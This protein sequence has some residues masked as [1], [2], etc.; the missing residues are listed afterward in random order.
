V[1]DSECWLAIDQGGHASRAL[2]FDRRGALVAGVTVPVSTRRPDAARV[3]HDAEEIVASV[4]AAVDGVRAELGARARDVVA[5]GLAT[6][7]SSI[8]CWDRTDG[9]ALSPI[10]SWQDRRAAALVERL[11]GAAELVRRRSGL[12][13]SPH[14]GASKLRWCLDHLDAVRGAAARGRLAWGPLSSFLLFRLLRQRPHVVDPASASRT[15]LFDPE[16]GSW[17]RDLLELFGLSPEAL[18]ACVQSAH[19]FGALRWGGGELPLSVCTGDQSAALFAQGWPEAGTVAINMG[20]G[21][22]LQRPASTAPAPQSGLLYSV[23]WSDASGPLR[24]LE[25]TVNGAGAALEVAAGELWPAAPGRD[26]L[27][28]LEQWLSAPGPVPIFL[29]GVGGLGSPWWVSAFPSRFVGAGAP[30]RRMVAVVESVVFLLAAN[31]E[32]FGRAG[33]VCTRLRVSGGL[34]GSA[35]VCQRLA[36]V[37]GLPV[38]RP[39]GR[40]ATGR[41]VWF[42]L[43]RGPAHPEPV[44]R[45]LPAPRPDLLD[46]AASWREAMDRALAGAA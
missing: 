39:R 43:A 11:R 44:D 42:L 19:P 21:A 9:R 6:Q 7:R 5:A 26:R 46:R 10:L 18:P 28:R 33:G 17:D 37:S 13:L 23:A 8:A 30:S 41:G 27:G 22:F 31:L 16:A 45:F 29:N 36:D 15:L 4:R 25:G 14:Y 2:V 35:G 38:D 24:V 3:E 20:T 34:A 12:V 40:E 32:A 1:S